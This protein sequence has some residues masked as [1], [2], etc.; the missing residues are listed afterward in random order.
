MKN[1]YF[2]EGFVSRDEKLI[3]NMPVYLQPVQRF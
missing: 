2:Q 1:M 3:L